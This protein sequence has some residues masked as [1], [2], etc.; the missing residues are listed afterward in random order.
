MYCVPFYSP[1]HPSRINNDDSNRVN[2]ATPSLRFQTRPEP[3]AQRQSGLF[4]L[5]TKIFS[6]IID[7]MDMLDMLGKADAIGTHHL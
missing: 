3:L 6:D 7:D 5:P 2:D 1:F 4:R